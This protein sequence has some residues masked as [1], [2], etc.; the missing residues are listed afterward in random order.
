MVV[1][2]FLTLLPMRFH[3]NYPFLS[4]VVSVVTGYSKFYRHFLRL[5]LFS[6]TFSACTAPSSIV[7]DAGYDFYPIEKGRFIEYDV[8]ETSYSLVGL[9]ITK[10]YQLKELQGTPFTDLTN[11]ESFKLERFRRDNATQA[12]RLDSVW[13]VKQ[14]TEQL[15]RTENNIAY[16]KLAYP[17]RKGNKWNG[18]TLNSLGK[19]DYEMDAADKSF[20]YNAQQYDNVLTV[21]QQD[22]STLVSQD[23]R[24]ERFAKGI[25]MLYK[26]ST[27]L[28][29][30]S[31]PGCVGQGKI[32]YGSRKIQM[33]RAYGKE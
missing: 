26:E 1:H 6:I 20:R 5:F 4:T 2:H 19:D 23:R 11:Q 31:Q 9:P 25:G 33:I 22:D 12:W 7:P 27:I 17:T 24:I 32:D 13:T 29:L 30:C 28:F 14:T 10:S 15:V 21:K 3:L 8:V 16:I 18:N